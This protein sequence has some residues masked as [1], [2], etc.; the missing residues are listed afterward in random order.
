MR[1]G[2]DYTSAV[3]QGAGIGRY[4][5]NLVQALLA[6]DAENDYVL[7]AATGGLDRA[8][9][10]PDGAESGSREAVAAAQANVGTPSPQR[11]R[12]FASR[13]DGVGKIL[14]TSRK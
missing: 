12:D 4:T 1:I 10:C 14:D 11:W 7:L 8:P 2:I 6:L 9:S 3:R 13:P 5:R